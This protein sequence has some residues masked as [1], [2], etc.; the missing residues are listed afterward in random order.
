MLLGVEVKMQKSTSLLLLMIVCFSSQ[1]YATATESPTRLDYSKIL[2]E[3]RR[4]VKGA[5]CAAVNERN[6]FFQAAQYRSE[7][8]LELK[9][10]QRDQRNLPPYLREW[11]DQLGKEITYRFGKLNQRANADDKLVASA[12]EFKVTSDG[13]ITD[14]TFVEGSPSDAFR[15]MITDVLIGLEGNPV[16]SFPKELI[17]SDGTYPPN[18]YV[19]GIF[20]QNYGKR[21]LK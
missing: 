11:F 18:I 9:Y 12:T 15:A 20:S 4:P 5:T 14:I 13:K 17:R 2:W 6:V 3:P 10:I 8:P 7:H 19:D 1:S 16:L 21:Y